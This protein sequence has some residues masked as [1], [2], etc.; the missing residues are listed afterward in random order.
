MSRNA[1]LQPLIIHRKSFLDILMKPLGSPAAEQVELCALK[2]WQCRWAECSGACRAIAAPPW[3]SQKKR[4]S[5]SW[6]SLLRSATRNRNL[7]ISGWISLMYL[8]AKNVI[9]R[10]CSTGGL[11]YFAVSCG[12]DFLLYDKGNALFWNTSRCLV[13]LLHFGVEFIF[14]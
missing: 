4:A 9:S 6:Y 7:T 3:M 10:Y 8:L 1:L 2:N 14:L 12:V 5:L 11:L 13:F